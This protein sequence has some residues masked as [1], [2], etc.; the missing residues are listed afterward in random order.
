MTKYTIFRSPPFFRKWDFGINKREEG[1][2]RRKK[3]LDLLPREKRFGSLCEYAYSSLV[4]FF[5]PAPH[6]LF[7]EE[8]VSTKSPL[9]MKGAF[10]KR[11]KSARVASRSLR[12]ILLRLPSPFSSA[13]LPPVDLHRICDS[14]RKTK[15]KTRANI[16]RAH[17]AL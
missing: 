5:F 15:R 7:R 11:S 12:L 10:S 9:S 1:M 17:S 3:N 8:I 6:H 4:L 14:G 16:S 13:A 2:K